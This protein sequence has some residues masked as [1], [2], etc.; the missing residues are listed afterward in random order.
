MI[1]KK[2]E[3]LIILFSIVISLI[4]SGYNLKNFDKIKI[5][6]D[7]KH[8]NQ[9]LYADLDAT[10][11]SASKFKNNLDKGNNFFES[12]P[13]YDRFLLSSVIVGYYY[14]ILGQDIYEKKDNGQKVIKVGNHKFGLIIFQILLYYFSILFF[15][16]Q[17]KNKININLHRL[18]IIF[19]CLEPSLLQWHSSLWS[20][21]VFLSLLLFLF[22]LL[23]RNSQNFFFN[24][25]IGL[26]L[27]ILFCQRGVAFLYIIPV[28]TYFIL[29]KKKLYNYFFLIIGLLI[30]L[31]PIGYNHLKKA[32]VFFI[33]PVAHQFNSYYYYFGPTILADRLKISEKDAQK[34]LSNEEQMWREK[35][36]INLN[37][38]PTGSDGS[39]K[40]Y[41]INTKYRNK[42]FLREAIK[43]PIF[44]IKKFTKRVMLMCII[45]PFWVHDH[46]YA[47][48]TSPEAKNNPKKYYHK[49]MIINI[50]YSVFIYIFTF[51]GILKFSQKI[52][53]KDKL[54][55]FD[56]FLI[57][58]ILSIFYFIGIAGFW[59]NPKYF[60]PCMVSVILFFSIGVDK[61][62]KDLINK[63]IN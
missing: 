63:K 7:N 13:V 26:S 44:T 23:L 4:W 58:N 22:S 48:K 39:R 19:L 15:S 36:D 14:Y 34:I 21:S 31:I 37:I 49:R 56:N 60:A 29:T 10:W 40:D 33:L 47:D 27:G 42:I 38:L 62:A 32:D 43:N 35:N 55:D 59:G 46:F 6:F 16:K 18:I 28:I 51:L 57:F 53:S 2:F 45:N 52:F 20:E 61:I 54:N 8:Y 41:L 25:L 5:N 9:L 11:N 24:F 12:I 50:I 1:K 30:I 3:L 17:L